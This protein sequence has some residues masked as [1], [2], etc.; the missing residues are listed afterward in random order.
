MVSATEKKLWVNVK[1]PRISQP[2][3]VES[4]PQ[5]TQPWA[6]RKEAKPP[7]L[8]KPTPFY[9]QAEGLAEK[10]TKLPTEKVS[11][12]QVSRG[13][14]QFIISGVSAVP[15]WVIQSGLGFSPCLAHP[16]PGFTAG[17]S[18]LLST[19]IREGWRLH[20]FCH[21]K[22]PMRGFGISGW[23]EFPLPTAQLD[24]GAEAEGHAPDTSDSW[25]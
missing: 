2:C 3:H 12:S 10:S 25:Q 15:T 1:I 11:L 5:S 17:R 23:K 21:T 4:Q 8:H 7:S 24:V 6:Q 19:S 14:Q 20:N 9:S 22:G 13:C 16:W 18:V